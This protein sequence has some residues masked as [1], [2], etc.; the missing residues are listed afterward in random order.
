[1]NNAPVFT[2]GLVHTSQSNCK[3]LPVSILELSQS[4]IFI[5]FFVLELTFIGIPTDLLQPAFYG[6][7]LCESRNVSKF[8]LGHLG[9]FLLGP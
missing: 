8:I 1:M 9:H 7:V 3:S 2:L 6:M 4:I 5:V